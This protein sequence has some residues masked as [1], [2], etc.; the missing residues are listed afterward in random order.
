MSFN[1]DICEEIQNFFS[2]F[3]E[4]SFIKVP[5][6]YIRIARVLLVLNDAIRPA[7]LTY[8]EPSEFTKFRQSIIP[9]N[10]YDYSCW[11]LH[12]VNESVRF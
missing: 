12:R 9:L 11:M 5:I 8:K 2:K 7:V 1:L 3:R 4:P 10:P 6:E